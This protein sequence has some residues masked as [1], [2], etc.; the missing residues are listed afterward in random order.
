MAFIYDL[1]GD[2][3]TWRLREGISIPMVLAWS[4]NKWPS[5]MTC[6]GILLHGDWEKTSVFLNWQTSHT[7]A[8]A[9]I[10]LLVAEYFLSAL[11]NLVLACA[12]T[13]SLLPTFC[14][15]MDPSLSHWHPSIL[16]VVV[17]KYYIDRNTWDSVWCWKQFH[18]CNSKAFFGFSLTN[19]VG[20][21]QFWQNL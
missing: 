13:C 1:F 9:S 3:T 7:R 15:R 8:R 19:Y 20:E 16:L 18:I 21:Q 14:D 4:M 6:S 12:T 17:G 5:S 11:V 2:F 10:S